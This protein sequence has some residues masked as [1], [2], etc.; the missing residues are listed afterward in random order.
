MRILRVGNKM[1]GFTLLELLMVIA[2]VGMLSFSVIYGF[3]GGSRGKVEHGE[4]IIERLI[5]IGRR[6][7]LLNDNNSHLMVLR[8]DRRMICLKM[9]DNFIYELLPEGVE[10]M[11]GTGKQMSIEDELWEYEELGGR[12][13][14]ILLGEGREL[15][16]YEGK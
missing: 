1:L 13:S 4:R 5:K 6:S 11:M 7:A 8:S 3:G 16:I 15:K 2:L 14:L 12:M 10:L 9:G